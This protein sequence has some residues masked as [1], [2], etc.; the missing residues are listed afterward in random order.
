[1]KLF[2]TILLF[3]T[4]AVA[5]PEQL[6]AETLEDGS[7]RVVVLDKS[8]SEALPYVSVSLAREGEKLPSIF[9]LTDD[10]GLVLFKHV[11]E[12]PYTLMIQQLGY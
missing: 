8:T 3:L 1:M 6:Q 5:L 11:P 9:G 2:K 12:G 10:S 7:L 4:L